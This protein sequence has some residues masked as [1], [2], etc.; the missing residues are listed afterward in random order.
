M[1]QIRK[2]LALA[3]SLNSAVFAL[4]LVGGMRAHSLSLI[5]DAVHNLS[6]ELALALAKSPD[7]RI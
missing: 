3:L 6:D 5:M 7:L 1:S 4:E 2:P